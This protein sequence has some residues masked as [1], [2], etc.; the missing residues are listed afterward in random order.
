MTS[1]SH[2]LAKPD[3][4]AL[5][6]SERLAAVVRQ[7]IDDAGGHIAFSHFMQLALYAPGLGYYSAG[8]QKFGAGG[9]FITAPEI[10][11]LFSS[12]LAE[13]CVS[14]M[15]SLTSA[16]IVEFGAGSG[17]MAADI[18]LHLE[19]RNSLPERYYIV[20]LSA[21][22][23]QRQQHT[24]Q[25]KCPHLLASVQW[26]T[27]LPNKPVNAIVLA[28]EVLDAMPV[29]LFRQ[30]QN[31]LQ[32]VFVTY[33]DDSFCWLN[34]EID[35]PLLQQRL[36]QLTAEYPLP[37]DY[38]SEINV[39]LA[40]WLQSVS[41]FIDTGVVL[42]IDYGYSQREYYHAERY[43]GSLQCFY[44][45]QVHNDP[46]ILLGLQDI[47]AHVDFTA[48]A[49]AALMADFSVLGFTTQ[50]MFLLN[51]QLLELSQQHTC[52]DV[53]RFNLN[54]QVKQLTLPNEMG[55]KFKVIAL[56]KQYLEPLQGFSVGDKLYSL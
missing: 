29:E 31:S 50:A 56:G 41:D 10:S 16:V 17:V 49:E 25:D 37:T 44:R 7:A 38:L 15:A 3:D 55:E 34:D 1:L 24:L 18:L 45:H 33:K 6:H 36:T 27:E 54:Q 22:L 14:I 52:D 48:V 12:C 19:A 26:L 20:D 51:N 42:L 47:T 21:D 23:I 9:D 13:Q 5:A 28:N 40:P 43:Q 32:Q 4:H 11:P 8:S 35:D 2:S 46:L 39:M 53:G 30:A